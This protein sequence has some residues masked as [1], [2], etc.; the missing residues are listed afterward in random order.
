[1]Q[2]KTI[3]ILFT[4][5]IIILFFVSILYMLIRLKSF[6]F[7][8][9]AKSDVAKFAIYSQLLTTVYIG[10]IVILGILI[11]L[12]LLLRNIKKGQVFI[13]LNIVYLKIISG[14]CIIGGVI[15][16]VS[17]SYWIVWLPIAVVGF[18]LALIIWVIQSIITKAME[19]KKEN[20]FT[21]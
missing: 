2:K 8:L 5:A 14:L 7:W 13:K 4:E 6:A 15:A 20:E 19:I 21:I 18:F 1:M 12:L 10:G 17:S 3:P 16:L 9:I 11:L